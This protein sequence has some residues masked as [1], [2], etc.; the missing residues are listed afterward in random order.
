M[1]STTRPRRKKEEE[2]VDYIFMSQEEFENDV[3]EVKEKQKKYKKN[4]ANKQ[5]DKQKEKGR[6]S[7]KKGS[8]KD[9]K[10]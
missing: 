6:Y 2:G 3:M 9:R 8:Q 10:S 7:K 1:S 4:Q 5:T